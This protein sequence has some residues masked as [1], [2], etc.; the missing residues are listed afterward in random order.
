MLPEAA[1]LDQLPWGVRHQG[2]Y[3][4]DA[5]AG[6]HPAA[7]ADAHHPDLPDVGAGKSADLEPGARVLDGQRR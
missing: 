6:V 3:V 5:S 7:V 1:T 4:W 2:Q